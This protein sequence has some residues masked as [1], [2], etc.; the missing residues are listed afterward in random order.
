[1]CEECGECGPRLVVIC[2][3]VSV[4]NRAMVPKTNG[5]ILKTSKLRYSI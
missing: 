2:P 3:R 1:M 4:W 5:S